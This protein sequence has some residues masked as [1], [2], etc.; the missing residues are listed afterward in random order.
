MLLIDS[1]IF[2]AHILEKVYFLWKQLKS[3]D[4]MINLILNQL[5]KCNN[6]L[7]LQHSNQSS[8]LWR[9]GVVLITTAQLHSTKL[10]LRF[11]AG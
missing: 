8:S 2:T 9:R 3:K 4:E 5:A 1:K 10:E 7:Q 11:C 6:M